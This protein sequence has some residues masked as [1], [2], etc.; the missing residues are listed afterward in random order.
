MEKASIVEPFQQSRPGDAS[1][2]QDD[3]WP[4]SMV[5]STKSHER[6]MRSRL[7]LIMN[8][9]SIGPEPISVEGLDS[10]EA[11]SLVSISVQLSP[12]VKNG[13]DSEE[14]IFL[15]QRKNLLSQVEMF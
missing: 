2:N 12:L 15:L 10:Y 9:N 13:N 8:S 14:K 7:G 11:G 3:L 1:T 5:W 6:D 4:D